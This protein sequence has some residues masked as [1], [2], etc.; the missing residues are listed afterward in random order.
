MLE[1]PDLDIIKQHNNEYPNAI[2]CILLAPEFDK[3]GFDSIIQRI[4]YLD[5]RSSEDIH[6]YCVG[7]GGYWNNNYAPD[8]KYINK[9]GAGNITIPWAFSQIKFALFINELEQET[10]WKYSGR[11]ELIILNSTIDFSQCITLD[12]SSMVEDKVIPSPAV[13][14]EKLIQYARE[15][16]EIENISLQEVYKIFTKQIIQEIIKSQSK[17]IKTV[18]GIWNKGKYYKLNDI[19]KQ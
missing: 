17:I 16:K 13:L 4:G 15:S 8:M 7:Y 18:W 14:F 2:C 12:I 1:A 10:S 19:R 3:L 9:S 11:T 6:F 5:L